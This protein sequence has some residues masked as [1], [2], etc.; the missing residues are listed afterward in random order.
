MKVILLGGLLVPRGERVLG[1]LGDSADKPFP[2]I[3]VVGGLSRLPVFPDCK[4]EGNNVLNKD[5]RTGDE[6][7]EGEGG[8]VRKVEGGGR[9]AK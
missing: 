8:M 5:G 6:E 3:I 9:E 4:V 7:G 1:E 2:S